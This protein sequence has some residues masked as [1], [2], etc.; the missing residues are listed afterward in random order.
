MMLA[1]AGQA[2]RASAPDLVTRVIDDGRTITLTGNTRPEARQANDRGKVA[3]DYRLDHMELLLRRPAGTEAALV[4]FIDGLHTK[5][6]P[7]FHRWLTAEQF[8]QTYGPSAHDIGA[9]TSWLTLHGFQ[10]NGV[11]S[12]GM[13]I[14][15]SGTAGQIREAFHTEIHYLEVHGARH[16]ANMSDP[17]IPEALAGVVNGIVSLH[18]FRPHTNF[19]PRPAYTFT[20]GGSTYEAVVPADLA[21]IYNLNP[22]FSA[23]ISGQGQTIVVIEDTDV[24]ST[25]DWSTFRSTF[26]LSGY[27]G[28]SFT[29]VHPTGGTSCTDPGVV[30]GNESEAEL[31]AEWASAAAPSAAIELASCKDTSTTFG[32]LIALQNLLSKSSPPA[33]VSIS[34]GECEAENGATANAAYNTAYQEAVALGVSVFVSAGDEGAASCDADATKST[35]GIGVS[36]FASTPYDVAVGGTDFGDAYAG[37]TATYWST[38]N[39]GT[40]GSA[41]SYIPEI[42]WNDS[43]ASVLIA[44]ASG[45]SATYGTSGFCNSSVGKEYYLTTASGSGGPSGC[46]TGSPSTSGVVSGSCKGYAKPSWQSVVGNPADGV[47]DLPDISLFAANGVWGHYYVYCDSDTRDDGAACTGAP[48][49]WSGA[50]GTSFASPI[51]AAIQALV[52]QKTGSRQGNPNPTYYALA[53]GEYGSGGSSICNSSLGNGT[54]GA[55]MFYD[56]TLGDMDVN[57]TGTHNCYLPG[58]KN[59]VLSLSDTAYQ[60]TYGTGTGWDFATGIGSVNAANLVNNW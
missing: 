32:G 35:H 37:S 52:N 41:K 38:G 44:T 33:I 56:T 18:D 9:V 55:C 60:K 5:S 6:S 3:D 8:G 29:Q 31:D 34:Y 48:S 51:L 43:C 23:G 36:G 10:V 1:G 27:S 21:T 30:S 19:K 45:Y 14:D 16:I 20:S 50:G 12:S 39:S 4:R 17:K 13:V 2:A 57:C 49:G 53:A 28:G 47:R 22:L 25:A 54:S 26:G 59:G 58:S 7:E 42:P 40:Y 15:F 11:H 24:Y 46:A